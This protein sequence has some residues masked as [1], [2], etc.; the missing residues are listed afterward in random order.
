[1]IVICITYHC[2]SLDTSVRGMSNSST[3]SVLF[4]PNGESCQ[5][6]IIFTIELTGGQ[7]LSP[8]FM[9]ED[10]IMGLVYKHT[11]VETVVVQNLDEKATLLVFPKGE[12]VEK[13]C[14]TL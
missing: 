2:H 13:I 1:M 12:E 6:A 10:I 11:N 9:N 4:I 8:V 5:R 3:V 14:S 7:V